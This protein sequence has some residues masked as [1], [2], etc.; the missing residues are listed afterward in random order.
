MH[1][2]FNLLYISE[3]SKQWAKNGLW[4]FNS[5]EAIELHITVLNSIHV[6]KVVVSDY[7]V[8]LVTFCVI[9]VKFYKKWNTVLFFV[10]L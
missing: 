10:F 1:D 2:E 5:S 9:I 4:K 8:Q 7:T 3:K 6:L